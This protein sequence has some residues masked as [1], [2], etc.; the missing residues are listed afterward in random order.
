MSSKESSY[1]ELFYIKRP[2][3]LLRAQLGAELW[4]DKTQKKDKKKEE[5]ELCYHLFTL[6]AR[7]QLDITIIVLVIYRFNIA[8]YWTWLDNYINQRLTNEND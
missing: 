5:E 1:K 7:R 2:N 6:Q 4:T 8:F 3:W